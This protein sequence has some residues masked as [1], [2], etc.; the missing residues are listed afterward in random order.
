M[1]TQNDTPI[2]FPK[3]LKWGKQMLQPSEQLG[4]QEDELATADFDDYPVPVY[5]TDAEG[6]LTY[7]NQACVAFAGHVPSIENGR[8]CVSWQL[9]TNDGVPL[10]HEACP[11][12]VAV[13]ERRSIRGVTAVA[14]RPDGTR[15]KFMPFPTPLFDEKRRFVGAINM[16][17]PEDTIPDGEAIWSEVQSKLYRRSLA[18]SNDA[19]MA[20][21]SHELR[22]PLAAVENYLNA[23]RLFVQ[24]PQR[25]A[26]AITSIERAGAVVR[27]LSNTLDGM[28]TTISEGVLAKRLHP[29]QSIVHSAVALSSTF[30]PVRPEV[31]VNP[32]DL[33]VSVSALQIE[34]VLM[35]LLKNAVEAVA[36]VDKPAIKIRVRLAED[37]VRIDVMDNGCGLILERGADLP[38]ASTKMEGEGIGLSLASAIIVHHEGRLWISD[39]SPAGTTVSFTLPVTKTDEEQMSKVTVGSRRA[40]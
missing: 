27:R 34:Q 18:R 14:V 11:M 25:T 20:M 7:F 32:R 26:Q 13:R 21:I 16:L 4:S 6:R 9:A 37:R 28:R 10:A 8:W 31:E 24:D 19:A 17:A 40:A 3:M 1:H 29:I 2:T 36:N 39:T 35:N 23:A 38:R 12:A 33:H 22:Q 15:R 30:L 5:M